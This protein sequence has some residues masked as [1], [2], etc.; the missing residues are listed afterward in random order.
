MQSLCTVRPGG[1]AGD[2]QA[3]G[4]TADCWHVLPDHVL[5]AAL[6]L[7]DAVPDVLRV[8][9]NSQADRL[10]WMYSGGMVAKQEADKRA[11]EQ[12]LGV[13]PVELAE[14][15]APSKVSTQ[16]QAEVAT[17]F[18]LT[19]LQAHLPQALLQ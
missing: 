12:L 7:P 8:G 3:C 19:S 2:Q 13:R 11:E 10:D 15:A 5:V 18:T 16:A 1:P 17:G 14:A 9:A 6:C 4:G